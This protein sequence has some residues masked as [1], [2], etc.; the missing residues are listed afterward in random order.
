MRTNHQMI[1]DILIDPHSLNNHD[2]LLDINHDLWVQQLS[3]YV[4]ILL[5]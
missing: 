5:K 4:V 2:A 3:V 1:F